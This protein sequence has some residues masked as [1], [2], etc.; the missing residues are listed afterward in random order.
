MINFDKLPPCP[1]CGA[2]ARD[3]CDHLIDIR[4][5]RNDR[6][7]L[8]VWNSDRRQRAENAL[9]LMENNKFTQE[10]EGLG[11]GAMH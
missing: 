5:Y 1:F 2:P 4:N 9:S 7:F 8:K 10:D 11:M 6:D 3:Y